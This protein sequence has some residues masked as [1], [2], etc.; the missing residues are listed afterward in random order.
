MEWTLDVCRSAYQYDD[1]GCLE[2]NNGVAEPRV[3][4]RQKTEANLEWVG[5]KTHQ[6]TTVIINYMLDVVIQV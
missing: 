1:K 4:R 3:L 5:K 6:K 2:A